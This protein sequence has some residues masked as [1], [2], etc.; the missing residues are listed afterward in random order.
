MLHIG[1]GY[2]T[3]TV[4]IGGIFDLDKT[5]Y[6]PRTREFLAI[7]EKN[8]KVRSAGYELPKSFLLCNDGE[9]DTVWLSQLASSTL[10][11]RVEKAEEKYN[12][13]KQ[14]VPEERKE[15]L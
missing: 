3:D 14:S 8:G 13:R 15:H 1:A 9:R 2:L 4:D 12:L 11:K 6:G 7:S 5:T 10:Q